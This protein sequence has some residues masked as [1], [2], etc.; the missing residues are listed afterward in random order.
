MVGGVRPVCAGAA[1]KTVVTDQAHLIVFGANGQVGRALASTRLPHGWERRLAAR[2]QVDITDRPSVEAVLAGM[3][4]GLVVNCA[5]FTAVDKAE[6]EAAL[7]WAV[8]RDGAAIV[9]AAA[10]AHGL[11]VLHLSTDFVFAGDK[12]GPYDESDPPRPL[13]VYGASKLAGEQAVERS[14]PRHL[15]LRTSWIFSP[16]ATCF[17]RTIFRL[18]R[19]RREVSVVTDQ[20]GG[21]TAAEHVAEAIAALAP[22]LASLPEG[23]PGF[24]LF[25]YAGTPALSRFAFAQAIAEEAERQDFAIGRLSPRLTGRVS[26]GAVRPANSALSSLKLWR[27]HGVKAP[28]WRVLL[29]DYVRR[30]GE[31]P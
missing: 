16:D 25:H 5:A 4:H 13:S 9:A 18:L 30:Y 7:A 14:N 6:G 29:P 11:P 17:P 27:C 12:L 1:G 8:N 23:E 20:I 31:S 19:E 15:L 24:G 10:A 28:D 22:R 26:E 21:P 2:P 3:S